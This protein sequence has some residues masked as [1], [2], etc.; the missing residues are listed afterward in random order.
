MKMMEITMPGFDGSTDLTD[1]L[2]MWVAVPENAEF[3]VNNNK[4]S[5]KKVEDNI[6]ADKSGLDLVFVDYEKIELK[7]EL[8]EC[9]SQ[10]EGL[11]RRSRK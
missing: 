3:V 10:L 1:N 6:S 5:V 8:D 4:I 11:A 2:V 9:E 7:S